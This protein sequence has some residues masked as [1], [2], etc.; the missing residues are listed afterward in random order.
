M[1]PFLERGVE[2]TEGF[3]EC[4]N[5]RQ[6]PENAVIRG[7]SARPALTASSAFGY[8]LKLVSKRCTTN[9]SGWQE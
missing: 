8:L 6:G 1:A 2:A 4:Q 9:E 3:D 5:T 7:C